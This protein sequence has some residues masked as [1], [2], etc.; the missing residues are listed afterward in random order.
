MQFMRDAKP[1]LYEISHLNSGPRL[2]E[3]HAATSFDVL[4][5]E[6]QLE[7]MTC[8]MIAHPIRAEADIRPLIVVGPPCDARTVTR[9]MRAGI[10][11]YIVREDLDLHS[12]RDSIRSAR[13]AQIRRESERNLRQVIAQL[14]AADNFA[15]MLIDRSSDMIVA[16]DLTLRITEF[17][18]A[19]ERAF[20]YTRDEMLGRHVSLL[21]ADPDQAWPVRLDTFRAG[22]IGEV[23]NRRR[24]GEQ[25]ISALQSCKLMD[26]NGEL[27]GVIGMSREVSSVHA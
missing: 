27:I 3:T 21:Y 12:L 5:F 24:N 1:L 8:D 22:F 17:N 15:Q 13:E 19:A 14:R 2:L 16:V 4:L 26:L 10:D 9:Y 20:G 25:F 7:G 6:D 11:D 23:C 18:R